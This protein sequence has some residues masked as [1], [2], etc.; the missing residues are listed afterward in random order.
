MSVYNYLS[1]VRS[2]PVQYRRNSI[3]S[4]HKT[5]LFY[6]NITLTYYY[7]EGFN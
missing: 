3:T 4:Q 2:S 1:I 6:T 5:K 7:G